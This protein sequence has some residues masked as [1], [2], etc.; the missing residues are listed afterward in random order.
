[1]HGLRYACEC[2][3]HP[4]LSG[5][6]AEPSAKLRASGA[7][8]LGERGATFRGGGATFRGVSLSGERTPFSGSSEAGHLESG[9]FAV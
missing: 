4:R 5:P 8:V 2:S 1:M 9:L 7:D 6:F 3:G